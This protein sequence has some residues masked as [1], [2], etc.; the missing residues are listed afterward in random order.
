[1]MRPIARVLCLA[2]TPV[3]MHIQ[4]ALAQ[5]DYYNIDAGRPV[6]IEDAYPVERFAFELQAAPLRLER[7]RGGVYQW[8]VEPEIAYGILRR[9][10]LEIG[11]PLAY[12][13]NGLGNRSLGLAGIDVSML[14]NLNVET[15]TLPAIGLAADVTLPVGSHAGN[16]TYVSGKAIVTRT[17]RWARIHANGRYTFGSAPESEADR[18]LEELSRWTAGVAIDRAIPLKSM[19]MIGEVFATQPLGDGGVEWNAG[20]GL[21]YQWSPRLAL[22]AGLGKAFS[23]DDNSWHFTLGAAYAF[24]IR[25]LMPTR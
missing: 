24:A 18:G 23:G 5:T 14:H 8:S 25:A 1:M 7:Q 20:A 10:Q 9:T 13:D 22:D 6:T 2:V 12:V 19:L 21:R 11:F 4:Q 16:R 3:L 15:E 17:F